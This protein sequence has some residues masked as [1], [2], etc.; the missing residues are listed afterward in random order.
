MSG[1]GVD[2]VRP[3]LPFRVW[4]GLPISK[5]DTSEPFSH[6]TENLR[7]ATVTA[8][9]YR[10]VGPTGYVNGIDHL[11]D[12]T[13]LARRNLEEDGLDPSTEEGEQRRG[14]KVVCGD[15]RAGYPPLG[16]SP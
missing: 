15:G 5:R 10:L 2:I 12:L 16:K 6:D 8:V 11:P 1:V 13:A 3:P 7:P 14:I 4:L 9:L